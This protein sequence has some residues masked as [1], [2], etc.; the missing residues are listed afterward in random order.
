MILLGCV[1][2]VGAVVG[3]IGA[4]FVSR[5]PRLEAPAV[6]PTTVRSEVRRHPKLQD[7]LADRRDPAVVT[8]LTLTLAVVTVVLALAGVG[9]L[10]AMIRAN[11]GLADFDL[12]FAEFA[13]RNA[14]PT[15]TTILR[16]LSNVGGTM[17]VIVIGLVVCAIELKRL[18]SRAVPAFL[19]LCIGGQFAVANLI[20]VLVDR[21]RPAID[22]LTG[23]SSTSFPS[24]HAVAAAATL[25]GCA[26][27]LT[28]RRS[29]RV[30]VVLA[31]IAAGLAA[32]V[33]STRVF[34]GVHWF[35]DVLAGLLIGWAWFAICSI[36]FGGPLLR[37]GVPVAVAE[38]EAD[39]EVSEQQHQRATR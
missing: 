8:G 19:V 2:A 31:G 21:A 9:I 27:L 39:H 15:S 6:R 32:A 34:L 7:F 35:T 14:S 11:T 12:R 10:L 16:D 5:W 1:V 13:A 3:L 20:K 24:G 17:G 4:A 36:A 38:S 26:F 37:F 33:A 25:A 28:R 18:P 30:R 22:Q 29:H 23:F